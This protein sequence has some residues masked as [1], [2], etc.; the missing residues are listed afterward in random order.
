VS[1]IDELL[2]RAQ[3]ASQ[4]LHRMTI[5]GEG[6]S[7]DARKGFIFNPA[8]VLGESGEG[9]GGFTGACCIGEA[10]SILSAA[11]CATAGGVYQG[12]FTVCFPNPCVP[13][14]PPC[15]E[16]GCGFEAFD[17]SGR[18]FLT[19]T[20]V[21]SLNCFVHEDAGTCQQYETI[22]LNS[23]RTDSYDPDSCELTCTGECD[24]TGEYSQ[25]G[26]PF[27][28]ADSTVFTGTTC[29]GSWSPGGTIANSPTGFSALTGLNVSA[30]ESYFAQPGFSNSDGGVVM[31]AT[32]EV[33][34][35]DHDFYD[36]GPG[37]SVSG[38][39]TVSVF[40]SDECIP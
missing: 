37:G 40:L 11:D 1:D 34:S 8:P 26:C 39:A 3:R 23:E 17:G 2:E 9:A 18:R 19:R 30:S 10:C 22:S 28:F 6:W 31:S 20:V 36:P 4:R 14:I 21:A 32:E 7:G 29:V 35:Y 25:T 16:G 24:G 15:P 13:V 33:W 5:R 38:S 12:D 27:P